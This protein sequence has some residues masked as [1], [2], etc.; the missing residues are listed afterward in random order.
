MGGWFML[1]I[2]NL[3]L[4]HVGA[5]PNRKDEMNGLV[6]GY[7]ARCSGWARCKTESFRTEE[8]L[9][10]WLERLAG[11]TPVVAVLLDSRESR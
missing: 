9:L 1:E 7:L 6:E 5:R 4:A 11:R 10:E 2:M 3:T 8:A